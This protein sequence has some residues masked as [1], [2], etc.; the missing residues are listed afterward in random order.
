MAQN[1]QLHSFNTLANHA[2]CTKP[3][4]LPL[5]SLE[6]PVSISLSRFHLCQYAL[7]HEQML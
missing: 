5:V 3:Q 2:G 1:D 4:S 6:H 7:G